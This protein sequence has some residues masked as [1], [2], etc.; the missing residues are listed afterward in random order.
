MKL[1]NKI[2]DTSIKI[3]TIVQPTHRIVCVDVSGSMSGELP[4]LRLHLKNKLPTMILPQDSLTLIWFS[5]RNQCGVLFEGIKLET[6]ADVSKINTM[7]DRYLVPVG[8]TSFK[9]PL[10]EVLSLITRS[11]DTTYTLSWMTDGYDNNNTNKEIIAACAAISE[12]LA[13]ATF[14]EYGYYANHNLLMEMAEEVGGSVVLSENFTQYSES[15]DSSMKSSVSGKKIKI[16]KIFAPYVIGNLLDGFVIA[17]PDAVGTVTLPANT[18]SYSYF[19]G[20]GDLEEIPQ[21]S[22]DNKDVGYA[23]SALIMRGEADMAVQLA[24]LIG[25]VTL[26]NQVQN[27]FSKQDYANVVELANAIGAG[28]KELFVDAPRK[29]NM[30]PDANAYNVLT[31]LM[32]LAEQEGNYL[33]ITHPAFAYNPIGSKRDTAELTDGFKPVFKDKSGDIKAAITSLKFDE[34]RP[35]VSILVK[36]PG[37]VTLP[38]NDLGFGD[39]IESFIWR[40]YTIVKDGIINVR[41]L[42][43]VLSK[44]TYDLFSQ[45]GVVNE[46]FKV[47]KTFVIDTKDY[48]IINRSMAAATKST[49][50]FN[51]CFNLYIL[52]TKQK[53]LGTKITKPEFGSKFAALYSEEGAKFLKMYGVGE[54]GFSPKTVKGESIDPYISKVLE[55]KLAGLSSIPTV[56]AVEKAIASGKALTPSQTIMRD[57]IDALDGCTDFEAELVKTKAMI[58]ELLNSIIMTKFGIILGKKW[59]TDMSS[60]EDNTKEIDFGIGKMIK[61]TALLED[62]EV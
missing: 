17:K 16:N 60:I 34:D 24:S 41:F 58:R 4:K 8:M 53:V 22:L 6:L 15:L 42:P 14:V 12:K 32:D 61:C 18:V 52:R 36:R 33:D 57:V 29:M 38:E 49:Q 54:G 23:V 46:P 21:D 39:S 20:A 62:K 59:F 9:E 40:N 47:G 44:A 10:C 35:N 51:A 37:T 11:N 30:M 26:Y 27:S 3:Q 55:I 13:S 45:L 19:D 25:D 28:K 43:L 50:L 1:I 56:E 31:M 5:G 48:P 2:I 7:I